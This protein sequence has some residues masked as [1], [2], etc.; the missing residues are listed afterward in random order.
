M[1]QINL[2][3]L[4]HSRVELLLTFVVPLAFFSIFALIFGSGVGADSAARIKVLAVDLAETPVSDAVLRQ[5]RQSPG[6]QFMTLASDSDAT[7]P[8]LRRAGFVV[9]EAA[10]RNGV[11]RG[12]VSVAIVLEPSREPRGGLAESH[13]QA[14]GGVL[15]VRLLADSSDAIAGQLVSAV[16]RQTLAVAN[17]RSAATAHRPAPLHPPPPEL[18]S[19]PESVSPPVSASPPESDTVTIEDVLGGDDTKPVVS[20]YAAGIAVM[21]LLFGA[22]GGGGVLLEE[23]ENRTLDRLFATQLTMDQ[24]LLGKWT[25]LMGLGVLQTTLM[26]LW[27]QAVFGVDLLGHWQGFLAIT[28]VTSA[29]AASF[30][31]LLATLCRTRN[32]LNGLSVIVVLTMSA[33]GGSMVPRYLMSEN[34]QRAGLWTFNAWALDGYNK[35][36]WRDLPLAELWPQ[37]AVLMLSGFA[38]LMAARSLA[39][40]WETA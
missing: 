35:V 30:G 15:S 1:I 27:G 29:A 8:P 19:P 40:R 21:F 18:A 39:V 28:L 23:Q 25:Y 38:F 4:L 20:M 37:L 3:R 2:R 13:T 6:L 31:L 34:L 16:V 14:S 26:F 10:A 33:L 17:G 9:D 12:Q 36:F 11:R 22:T 5:L 24:L 32:Q 7:A